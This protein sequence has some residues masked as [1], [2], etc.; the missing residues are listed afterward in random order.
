MIPVI[1]I[2]DKAKVNELDNFSLKVDLNKKAKKIIKVA[3]VDA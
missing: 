1:I 2:T 3:T